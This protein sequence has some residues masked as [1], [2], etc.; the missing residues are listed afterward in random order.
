RLLT[1]L[2]EDGEAHARQLALLLAQRLPAPPDAD[3]AAALRALLADR[4]LPADAQ[5][6]LAALILRTTGTEGPAAVEVFRALVS[7]L[8]KRKSVERLRELEQLTGPSAALAELREG[9]EDQVRMT[10]PRCAVQLRR[11]AMVPHLWQEHRLILDG[12]RVRE[13]WPMIQDWLEEYRRQ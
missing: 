8:G 10:C 4:R 1:R 3:L 7:D 5:L 11:R 2:A 9:I 13:P 6:R 12:H